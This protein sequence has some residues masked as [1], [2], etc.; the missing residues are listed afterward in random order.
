MAKDHSAELRQVLAELKVIQL[1][2]KRQIISVQKALRSVSSSRSKPSTRSKRT[3]QTKSP[4][5][6][7]RSKAVGFVRDRQLL[8]KKLSKK[9]KN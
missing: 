8:A 3:A 2:I 5:K 1:R 9:P 7:T 6:R 4:L